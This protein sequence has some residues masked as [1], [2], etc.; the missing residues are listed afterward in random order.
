MRIDGVEIWSAS[1]RI[2]LNGPV[3]VTAGGTLIIEAGTR[4][5][6]VVGSY[7]VVSRDGR[8]DARGTLNQPIELT[9]TATAKYPGCWG[10]VIVHGYARINAGTPTSPISATRSALGDCLDLADPLANSQRFGGCNDADDSGILRFVRIEYAERGLHLAGVGSGT[11]VQNIQANRTRNEGILVTGGAVDARHLFLTA[12]G[13]GLRW[14]G[15]W[16]GR[17]QGIA[18]QQDVVRFAAGIVG[19]NG[20][21]ANANPDALPRSQP[22]L[23]NI[24]LIAQSTPSNPLHATA[25]AL[26]IERGSAGRIRN[27]F[28]YAP[29]IA[30]DIAGAATCAQLSSGALTLRNALTGG[31]TALGEGLIPASCG[32][33]E[34]GILTNTA[35]SNVALPG[36]SGLIE[37]ENDLFLPDLRPVFGA[38]LATA[39]AAPTPVDGFFVEGQYVGA[40]SPEVAPGAI[41]WF[42]GWTNPAPPPAPIPTGAI[43][44]VVRSPFRGILSG[45]RVTDESTGATT[46]T[47]S[48]GAYLLELP[49]GTALLDVS[50]L[51]TGC[52]VPATRAGIVQP[53]D[54]TL[55]DLTVDCAPFPGVERI[56]AG[57]EFTCGVADQGTYCWGDNAFGQLGNGTTSASTIPVAVATSFSTVSSGA[58]H[59]CG[60]ESNG[61]VRCWGDNALGQLGDGSGINRTTPTAGPAGPFQLVTAGGEHTCALADDGNAY[62]WGANGNGQLGTGTTSNA[63][64]PVLVAGGRTFATLSA[65]RNHTCGLDLLGAAWCWGAN[66]DGQLGD[67]TTTDRT[68]PVAVAGGQVYGALAANGDAHSCATGATGTVR[69][70]GA[71]DAG[72][73]GNG[74][75]SPSSVP[76][77]V[78]AATALAQVAIGDRHSCG[79]TPDAVS[80]CWGRNTD[81]QI[82]DGTTGFQTVPTAATAA[83]RF[84]RVSGGLGFTC[85]VT[86]GA[87]TAE[88]NVIVVSRRSLLC[89]GRNTSG[90][91]GRGSTTSAL[92]PTAA[93]T[94]L[95]FP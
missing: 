85:A 58:R 15:G 92:T 68:Q 42:S 57:D 63:M 75:T 19:Q 80:V 66:A 12:N 36:A 74:S 89:W 48:N 51:P 94:G 41:P 78:Q 2:H 29:Q 40:I 17:A 69:C 95:T 30:L 27:L 70:W 20:I 33:T 56:S 4:V 81:G 8:I 67:G 6:G 35:D 28:I 53:D 84:N 14:T 76:V 1:T 61:I 60:R 7:I 64:S 45:V 72:Q 34:L 65:G 79:I 93:A 3:E 11:E 49:A 88:D 26:V 9:C 50:V 23:Y 87:V 59:A 5:E 37:S 82:G 32:T 44:G 13:T 62:C 24:T 52:P 47:A 73:L 25:R 31:A 21:S 10:G 16:R 55:L 43:R 22:Q 18:V 77:M 46:L 54:T 39:V 90:Q 38:S 71:N 86:F 91:F 83:A